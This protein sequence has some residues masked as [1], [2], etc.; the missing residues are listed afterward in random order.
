MLLLPTILVLVNQF[1]PPSAAIGMRRSGEGAI[2]RKEAHAYQ[3]RQNFMAL[4]A[5]AAVFCCRGVMW[6]GLGLFFFF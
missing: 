3:S 6:L 5:A 2:G 4:M 1:R